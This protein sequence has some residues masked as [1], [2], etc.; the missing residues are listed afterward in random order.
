MG[1]PLFFAICFLV[2]APFACG[3]L[4]PNELQCEFQNNPVGV[5]VRQPRLSW[6]L[7]PDPSQKNQRQNAMQVRIGPAAD[8]ENAAGSAVWIWDSGRIETSAQHFVLPDPAPFSLATGGAY[9]WQVRV[10]D[11]DG[12][13]SEWSPV[14]RWTSGVYEPGLWDS[15]QWIGQQERVDTGDK[16]DGPTKK[17]RWFRRNFELPAGDF[18][19]SGQSRH[20]PAVH[21]AS[22]GYHELYVNGRRVDDTVL[23]PAVSRL[24]HRVYYRTY[25]ISKLLR[26]GKN[27]VAVWLGQGW[28]GWGNWSTYG[29][30]LDSPIK[31][32]PAFKLLLTT[33]AATQKL[34]LAS[35]A[36]WKTAPAPLSQRGQWMYSGF[37]GESL[38]LSA[39]GLGTPA[40]Q[41]SHRAPVDHEG[42]WAFPAF[43]DSAWAAATVIKS[44]ESVRLTAQPVQPN[45][46]VRELPA[47]KVEPVPGEK[48]AW[49]VDF[50][51]NFN[52]WVRLPLRAPAGTQ[53][54]LHYS[55]RHLPKAPAKHLD[56]FNQVDHVTLSGDPGRDVFENRF[57]YHQFRW[58]TLKGLPEK[59]DISRFRGLQIRT[60]YAPAATFECSDPLLNRLYNTTLHTYEC[61]TLGG[62]IV[63]CSH[64]ERGGYGAEGQASMD[65]GMANF[66]SA[67]LLRKWAGDWRDMLRPDGDLPHCAPTYWGGGGPAWKMAIANIPIAAAFRYGD[68]RILA[69]NYPAMRAHLAR[70]ERIVGE[71]D[72]K[73]YP[74][75]GGSV[76]EN[77]GD[78]Y[79]ATRIDPPRS[80]RLSAP[81]SKNRQFF[82]NCFLVLTL[83]NA[84]RAASMLAS[85][86]ADPAVTGAGS[87]AELEDD[88][89]R[90]ATLAGNLRAAI[91]KKFYLSGDVAYNRKDQTNLALA[92]IAGIPP[93]EL[94][95]KVADALEADIR[96]TSKGH[97]SSGVLGTWLQLKHLA[98]ANR[99]DLIHLM[100]TA[101]GVPGWA[102]F[103]EEGQTTI[104]E[105]WDTV[106]APVYGRSLAHSSYI[107]IG[108]W[109]IEGLAGI[110]QAPDSFGG[111]KLILAPG[112]TDKLDWV[113]A[114]HR[115]PRGL[116]HVHWRREKDAA[117][118]AGKFILD[119]TLPPNTETS[120]LL[121]NEREPRQLGSGTHHFELP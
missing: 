115:T 68:I 85:M 45:R 109:F 113:K 28:A 92:L 15:A 25:D 94:R 40:P 64:R 21:I 10:W 91:H 83:D 31:H 70:L 5:E 86:P 101:P 48:D 58:L 74:A 98:A 47:L 95:A 111:S 42:S 8:M 59:P 41:S 35:D 102:A 39:P 62:Y 27:T 69:E 17:T 37:G 29:L 44:P 110:R 50:G 33:S 61:L 56:S 67:A 88:A 11:Q 38:D 34:L 118:K 24:T 1:S 107:S 106:K 9:Q 19:P 57:N 16:K 18:L 93:A 6:G 43:D 100:A 7:A 73:L 97:I 26:P 78:W 3:G 75:H 72:G 108:A 119:L 55:E 105:V 71:S 76:W 14:A 30:S 2:L 87:V 112:A 22:F 99:S 116:V 77:I 65:T 81:I 84:A 49:R 117:G 52:G 104:P 66:D 89:R 4:V 79:P 51:V 120:L 36:S 32:G 46:I 54:T 96:E 80:Q 90:Y 121:P 114:S 82:N 23:N 12:K 13:S 53:V 63:D 103:L 60:D 20:S